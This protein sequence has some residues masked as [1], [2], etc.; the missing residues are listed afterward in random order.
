MHA[1]ATIF[2]LTSKEYGW[3][4]MSRKMFDICYYIHVFT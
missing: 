3:R 4:T 1:V 2:V